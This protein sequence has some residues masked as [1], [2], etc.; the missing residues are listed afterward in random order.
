MRYETAQQEARRETTSEVIREPVPPAH[1][2]P[3]TPSA[4]ATPGTAREAG[5]RPPKRASASPASSGPRRSSIQVL[6]LLVGVSLLS[7]ATI[8]FLVYAFITFGLLTRSIIIG[9]ITI[10]TFVV[11]GLL[12][13]E[14]A[15]CERETAA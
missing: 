13:L 15:S 9:A 1:W 11:T 7:I 4:S 12:L 10:A 6:L 5:G 2:F 3:E 14:V 8:F